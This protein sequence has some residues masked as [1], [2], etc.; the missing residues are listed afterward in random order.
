[1]KKTSSITR[2]ALLAGVLSLL[3]WVVVHAAKPVEKVKN[4]PWTGTYT[5][6]CYDIQCNQSSSTLTATCVNE[7][8]I[9]LSA[10][11]NMKTC[12]K[13]STV[14][15]YNGTLVCDTPKPLKTK[16]KAQ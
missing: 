6:S 2:I 11:L 10:T 1:M 8:N 12:A 3:P 15:N 9:G 5:N 7:Q 14:S 13:K 16:L 4:C